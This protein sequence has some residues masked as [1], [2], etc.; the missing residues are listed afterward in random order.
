MRLL[1]LR[2]PFSTLANAFNKSLLT[3]SIESA[4]VRLMA[5]D[6]KKVT[7]WL[8]MPFNPRMVSDGRI[9]DPT[10]LSNVMKNAVMRMDIRLGRI[11][12]AFPSPRVTSRIM[13]LPSVRAMRPDTVLP[14]EARRVMGSAVDYHD[15]FWTPLSKV[16]I[17]QNY[18]LLAAPKGELMTLL[19]T[20]VLSGLRP[21]KVDARALALARGVGVASGFILNVEIYALD[22]VV[23]V[24]YVPLAV[25]HRELQVGLSIGDLVEEVIDGFQNTAEYYVDRNPLTPMPADSPL[26]LTGGHPQI[27]SEFLRTIGD[28]LRRDLY[29]PSPE[30]DY[31]ENFPVIQYIVNVGLAL[32]NR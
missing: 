18:Y 28:G 7:A 5:I 3:V 17:E 15:L 12:A 6:G 4:S 21:K 32:K 22:V 31:P 10:G 24:N 11:I 20:L 16:G 27:G 25:S 23:V 9:E 26:I 13:T 8:N 2:S 14:R 29:L 1:R 19:Q 30:L